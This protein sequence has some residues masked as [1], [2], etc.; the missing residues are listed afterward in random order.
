MQKLAIAATIQ[1]F[2]LSPGANSSEATEPPAVPDRLG[3]LRP[4]EFGMGLLQESDWQ[5]KWIVMGDTNGP[6]F[7]PGR[8]GKAIELDG[9][10][11]DALGGEAGT[12]VGAETSPAPRFRFPGRSGGCRSRPR[13]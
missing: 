3:M 12:A 10:L 2:L 8:L 5:G 13:R 11:D 9:N 1:A 4:A 6:P 7:V